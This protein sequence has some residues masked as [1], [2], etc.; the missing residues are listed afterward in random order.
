MSTSKLIQVC[1]IDIGYT[2][3]VQQI[4]EVV[5]YTMP[6]KWIWMVQLAAITLIGNMQ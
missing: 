6:D 4:D 2:T 5:L 3:T 1:F